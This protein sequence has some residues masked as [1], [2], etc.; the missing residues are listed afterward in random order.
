MTTPTW[1]HGYFTQDV[2]TAGFFRETAPNCLDF[3]ALIKGHTPNR[4]VGEPFRDLELGSGMGLHLCLLAAA[5][6]EGPA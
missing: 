1:N 6:P 5:Y 3:A 2:Y 4:R